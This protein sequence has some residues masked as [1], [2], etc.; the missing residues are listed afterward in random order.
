A[1]F[2]R[3]NISLNFGGGLLL[4]SDEPRQTIESDKALPELGELAGLATNELTQGRLNS[5]LSLIA[6]VQITQRRN[7]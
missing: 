6:P 2:T 5:D 4:L 3:I 7:A 1:V